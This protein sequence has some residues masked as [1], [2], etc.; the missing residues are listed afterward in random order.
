MISLNFPQYFNKDFVDA[1]ISAYTFEKVYG[2]DTKR[3]IKWKHSIDNQDLQLVEFLAG[4]WLSE[5]EYPLILQDFDKILLD[6]GINK[7]H[8]HFVLKQNYERLIDSKTGTNEFAMDPTDPD[9]WD[10]AGQ[11]G[12]LAR[13]KF[14]DH[15]TGK[16]YLRELEMINHSLKDK[17]Q[18]NIN[19]KTN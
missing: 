10:I 16:E 15:P 1:N 19:P 4:N 7:I 9:N 3:A 13:M 17:Y 5:M 2:F 18:K 8:S 12:D 14:L 11:E 6:K